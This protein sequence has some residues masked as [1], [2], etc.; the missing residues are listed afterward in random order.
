[1]TELFQATVQSLV[2]GFLLSRA[3]RG[4]GRTCQISTE[5]EA[6][7]QQALQAAGR[8]LEV[9]LEAERSGQVPGV[10]EISQLVRAGHQEGEVA[11]LVTDCLVKGASHYWNIN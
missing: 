11:G 1:M 6:V 9:V 3:R 7:V 4:L 2:P 8:V 10:E 5:G